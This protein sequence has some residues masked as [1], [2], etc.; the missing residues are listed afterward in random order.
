MDTI[1]QIKLLNIFKDVNETT[2]DKILSI[3][4]VVEY[5]KKTM[6]IR[7]RE[8]PNFIYIQLSGKSVQYEVTFNGKRK[9]FFVLGEGDLLNGNVFNN[10]SSAMHC[11]T[12]EK[13]R[14]IVI[15][16]NKFSEIMAS[17]FAL[18]RNVIYLQ[19]QKIWK[20]SRHLI[21]T[22]SSISLEKRLVAKLWKMSLD[23]GKDTKEGRE[24]D[25]NLSITLLAD[26]L[27]APRES[28][29]RICSK[30]IEDKYI[31]IDKKRFTIIDP[32]HFRNYYKNE[33]N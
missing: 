12:I 22:S 14:F 24:I 7:T 3:G 4:K 21:N 20:L 30:L 17:D 5:P 9:V 1:N 23:F 16:V 19:E 10:K 2:L 29:S 31:I 26:L 15:P 18:T 28:V 8:K 33:V 13:S 6:L 32:D 27:G 11:E 25:M